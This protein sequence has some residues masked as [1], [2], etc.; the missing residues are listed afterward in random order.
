[1]RTHNHPRHGEILEVD[2]DEKAEEEAEEEEEERKRMMMS[3]CKTQYIALF[4]NLKYFIESIVYRQT[5]LSGGCNSPHKTI[6]APPHITILTLPHKTILTPPH[7]IILTLPLEF[8]S[9]T[10]E[11]N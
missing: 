11:D 6:L 3:L 8:G 2:D 1:M 10:C 5:R 4:C 7:K 9:N